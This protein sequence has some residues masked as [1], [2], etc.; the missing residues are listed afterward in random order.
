MAHT[1]SIWALCDDRS[2]NVSQCLGVATVLNSPFERKDIRYNALGALPNHLLGHG[3]H[4]VKRKASS[5]LTPP[6]PDLV[7]AA[8]RRTAPIARAIKKANHGAT[9]LVQI[10]T[11]TGPLQDFDLIIRP[12]HDRPLKPTTVPSLTITGAAHS[13]TQAKIDAAHRQWASIFA[14]LPRP[15]SGVLM[16]GATKNK[17]FSQDQIRSF[18]RPC[19]KNRGQLARHHIAAHWGRQC[20][21]IT[22][23]LKPTQIFLQMGDRRRRQPLFWHPCLCRRNHS[24]RR[25]RVHGVRSLC[26]PQARPD[27]RP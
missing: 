18:E 12:R 4:T 6:W 8:G 15:Y 9:K 14:Y 10:M 16:G 19:C 24:D 3:F 26:R 25:Q 22:Q 20:R 5:D 13:V 2:G 7:I 17:T 27:F 23:P 11:P 1:K 21:L